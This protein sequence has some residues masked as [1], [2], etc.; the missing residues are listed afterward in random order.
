MFYHSSATPVLTGEKNLEVVSFDFFGLFIS[1]GSKFVSIQ[2]RSV[3]SEVVVKGKKLT[4]D[5]FLNTQGCGGVHL[6]TSH[7]LIQKL[8]N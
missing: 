5:L 1:A 8:T 6:M 7:Y 2:T 3:C 4:N